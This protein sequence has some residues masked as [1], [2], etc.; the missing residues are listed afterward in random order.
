MMLVKR[1]SRLRSDSARTLEIIQDDSSVHQSPVLTQRSRD[2]ST[3]AV[4]RNGFPSPFDKVVQ[5]WQHGCAPAI[6]AS[7]SRLTN[8]S[9]DGSTAAVHWNGFPSP[10][11]KLVQ[12]WQHCTGWKFTQYPMELHPC[13][14]GQPK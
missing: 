3:A 11:D 6:L 14:A 4:H 1:L 9:R 7:L 2:G 8:F 10:F 13:S 5:R 12:R